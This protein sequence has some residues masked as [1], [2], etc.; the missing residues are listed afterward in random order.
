LAAVLSPT[1]QSACARAF[2]S[3]DARTGADAI[4]CPEI[5]P[6]LAIRGDTLGQPLQ[7]RGLTTCGNPAASRTVIEKDLDR[8]KTVISQGNIKLVE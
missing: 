1:R 5:S 7:D 6:L 4:I 2:A 8:W 3:C